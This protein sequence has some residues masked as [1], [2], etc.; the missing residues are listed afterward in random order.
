MSAIPLGVEPEGA[1]EPLRV[2]S[3]AQTDGVAL[4]TEESLR[5]HD[6]DG[7][8]A[9]LHA[10]EFQVLEP[11][12]VTE[13]ADDVDGVV[14][15]RGSVLHR[16]VVATEVLRRDLR[17]VGV[18]EDL[19][20]RVAQP[21]D[22]AFVWWDE[23]VEVARG[24]I[25]PVRGHGKSA[26][27]RVA[28]A[29]AFECV[30]H[31][32][33]IVEFHDRQV[34]PR[35]RRQPAAPHTCDRSQVGSP[36]G[37]FGRTERSLEVVSVAR[38]LLV[39]AGV[40]GLLAAHELRARGHDVLVVD[41]G[42]QPG[43]RLATRRVG[44][45]TFDT[46][47]QFLTVRDARVRAHLDGWLGAGVAREWFRGSPDEPPVA[48]EGEVT[49]DRSGHDHD[50]RD[51]H[52]RFRGSP[53]M[54]SI[55]EHLAASLPLHLGT[56]VTRVH[57]T[58]GRWCLDLA[59]RHDQPLPSV[60]GDA[61]LLTPPV[62]Q[63]RD[64]L[65]GLPL[66]PTTAASL[67]AVRFD[68]CIAVLA[69]PDGPT[70]LGPRGAIRLGTEPVA[71]LT[72]NLVTGAS[73]TPAVT[74]HASAAFSRARWDDPDREVARDLLAAAAPTLGTTA[75]GVYVHRWRYAAP[76]GPPP[77]A[78]GGVEPEAPVLLDAIE[79]APLAIAGDGLTAGRVEGAAR[80]GL[81][82]ADALD[83]ALLRPPAGR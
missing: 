29:A 20:Q 74:V 33:D 18:P 32:E 47:A 40:A 49:G 72:D 35:R 3:V 41:K 51:G 37:A 70:A 39:G 79:G 10:F 60:T 68:P 1:G 77:D 76:I 14:D 13:S 54:R 81:A 45:A 62:P 5:G 19:R 53:T 34:M 69:R 80:S 55:A 78:A 65:A 15:P 30:E 26:E 83:A 52:P 38:V 75:A 9:C 56:R 73:R 64:L 21:L 42:H 58:G 6:R 82:A 59:D 27:D 50:G 28:N 8:L 43:G 23:Q 67:D 24:T 61:L 44:D 2:V 66:A 36:S 48:P 63:T 17:D 16:R 57:A 7:H 11:E 12:R 25:E 46:G 31:T 22:V 71:W 4:H